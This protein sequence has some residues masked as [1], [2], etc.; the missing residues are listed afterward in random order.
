[1]LWQH[2]VFRR[3]GEVYPTWEMM[4]DRRKVRALYIAGCGF[5]IRTQSVMREFVR[6]LRESSATVEKASLLLIGFK[7]YRL[8]EALQEQTLS[9]GEALKELFS[10]LGG[11]QTVTFGTS[12]TSEDISGSTAMRQ[13]VAEVQRHLDGVTD[14][15]LDVS[16]LPRVIYLSLLTGI[17]SALV[18]DKD[19]LNSLYAN[20][21]TF[22]VLVAEDAAL[23]G[24]IQSE[25]PSNDLVYIPGFSAALQAESFQ[26]WP[27]VWFPVLGEGKVSQLEKVMNEVIPANAEICPILPH[28]SRDARRADRLL[29]QYKEP[30]FDARA[31]PTGNI[32]L[33]HEG[34]PFEAYRQLFEAMMRYRKSM[35]IM[36]GCRLV[37][38]PLASKLISIGAGLACFEMQPSDVSANYRVA[39][40]YAEP[41]RYIASPADLR[42]SR[43]EIAALV[44]TGH[45]Y[46]E[47][48]TKSHLA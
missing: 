5:D 47:S 6:S 35:S 27:L 12:A 15:I 41:T 33:A 4:F 29:I 31:T 44:L 17:L 1:M 46:D 40:P 28:P 13:C 14:I 36:G 22:Q 34:H 30:L 45:A 48:A 8:D 37:V 23:D 10:E 43:P 42:Q 9:N 11:H 32:L 2:Y 3:A 38:T 25:D 26:D 7:G 20:D 18:P 21:V 19:K 24:K 16:S 39:I